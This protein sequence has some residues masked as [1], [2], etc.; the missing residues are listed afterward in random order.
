[1]NIKIHNAGE[2]FGALIVGE[3]NNT[4]CGNHLQLFPDISLER[5]FD[6]RSFLIDNYCWKIILLILTG[7]VHFQKWYL[8][9]NLY[10][11]TVVGK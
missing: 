1:M 4:H 5:L 9:C 2:V 10:R 7:G 8:I 11:R 3:A 6:T